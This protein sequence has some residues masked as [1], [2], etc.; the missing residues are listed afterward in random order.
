[1]SALS[2]RLPVR[3]CPVCGDTASRP[4]LDAMDYALLRCTGCGHRYAGEVLTPACLAEAYYAE[5]DTH[6]AARS[7][8]AKQA[9]FV[10]YT[11]MLKEAGA[12]AGRVLDVGCNAGE[13]LGLF[14]G[15][16]WKVAGVEVSRGPAEYARTC[17]D[18]PVWIGP[19]EECLPASERF[20]LITMTHVL[21]HLVSPRPVLQCLRTALSPGGHLLLE[22]PNADDVLLR[23]W[24]GFYRPLCPGDHVSFF[25][26][27]SL[28]ALVEA[29]GFEVLGLRSPTHARD[30]VYPSLLSALDWARA[31][32]ARGAATPAHN[33]GGVM[34]QVRYRGRL[35][36]PLR[37]A[38]DTLVE[39]IDPLVVASTA[40]Q[41]RAHT[42]PVLVMVA[43]A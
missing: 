25:D 37:A 34:N 5:T 32:R 2:P 38:M 9:R 11:A 18:A 22:V 41:D 7:L 17:L 12:R 23:L 28:R 42:G 24:R 19:V 40:A 39:V 13:L 31:L 15:A 10:E 36:A 29:A 30:V 43:R 26:V 16:G 21:E 35:R 14:A 33:P 27:R 1:M 20:D 3:A 8:R 4:W 6:L